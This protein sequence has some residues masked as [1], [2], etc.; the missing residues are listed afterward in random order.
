MKKL[1][2]PRQIRAALAGL[3]ISQPKLAE[4]TGLSRPTIARAA[5]E[6]EVSVSDEAREIIVAA[7]EKA[8]AEFVEDGEASPKGGEGVRFKRQK[9]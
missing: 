7:L 1:V 2:T 4:M 6:L 3:G 8:G 5:S 9:K